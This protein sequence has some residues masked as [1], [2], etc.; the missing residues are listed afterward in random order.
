MRF[1]VGLR[2]RGGLGFG[3][4][5]RRIPCGGGGGRAR[6]PETIYMVASIHLHIFQA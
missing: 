3:G 5:V 2:F 1:K 4:G 6:E